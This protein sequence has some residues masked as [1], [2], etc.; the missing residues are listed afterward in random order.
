MARA[1]LL[2]IALAIAAVGIPTIG[3]GGRQASGPAWPESA[4]SMVPDDWK[5]DGGESLEPDAPAEVAALETAE[6]VEAEEVDEVAEAVVDEPAQA[7]PSAA[8]AA[9]DTPAETAPDEIFV[10]E[11]IVIEIE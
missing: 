2:V 10:E 5:E 8:P 11:E 3:C 4:G 6:E 9:E 1:P 7:A